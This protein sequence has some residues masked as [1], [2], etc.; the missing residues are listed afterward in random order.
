MN[1]QIQ[2]LEDVGVRV[3]TNNETA[4]RYVGQLLQALN[5]SPPAPQVKATKLVDLAVLNQ[6]L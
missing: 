6:P 4:V 5:P 2:Q 3:E 1:S